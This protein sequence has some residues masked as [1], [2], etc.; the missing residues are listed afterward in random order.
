M[1]NIG[2][3]LPESFDALDLTDGK[4]LAIVADSGLAALPMVCDPDGGGGA[5]GPVTAWQKRC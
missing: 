4:R 5:P 2:L 1:C 3:R